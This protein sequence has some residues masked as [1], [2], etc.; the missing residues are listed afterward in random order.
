MYILGA[1][2]FR[3]IALPSRQPISAAASC[4]SAAALPWAILNSNTCKRKLPFL[5]LCSLSHRHWSALIAASQLLHSFFR[6][7]WGVVWHCFR[8]EQPFQIKS[9]L[10]HTRVAAEVLKF[11]TS[12]LLNALV[13]HAATSNLTGTYHEKHNSYQPLAQRLCRLDS[14]IS[15][16]NV[17]SQECQDLAKSP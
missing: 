10:F 14:I 15:V 5:F 13:I 17:I 7:D 3:G 6:P 4:N 9:L 1:S 16:S 12:S 8:P 11:I 2:W